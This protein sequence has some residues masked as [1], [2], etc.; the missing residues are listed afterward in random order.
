MHAVQ[1]NT[2]SNIVVTNK[3][4]IGLLKQGAVVLGGIGSMLWHLLI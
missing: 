3:E 2:A 1:M 4:Q